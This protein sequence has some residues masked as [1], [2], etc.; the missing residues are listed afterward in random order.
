MI[1][2]LFNLPYILRGIIYRKAL[3]KAMKTAKYCITITPLA[4]ALLSDSPPLCDTGFTLSHRKDHMCCDAFNRTPES[5][6][7]S[8]ENDKNTNVPR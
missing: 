2:D 3:A 5:H 1:L 7:F 8:R 4:E 6:G